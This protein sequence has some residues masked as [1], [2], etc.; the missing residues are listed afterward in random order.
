MADL[1]P[2]QPQNETTTSLASEVVS[3]VKA[4]ARNSLRWAAWGA[5]IGAVMLGAAG[6]WFFG[7]VGLAVGA[8]IGAIAGGLGAWFV[9]LSI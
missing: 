1:K 3:G 6:L 7:P 2:N 8:A 5:G 9:Y 4:E